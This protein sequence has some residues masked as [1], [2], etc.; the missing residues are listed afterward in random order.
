[1]PANEDINAMYVQM[2][3]DFYKIYTTTIKIDSLPSCNNVH[4]RRLQR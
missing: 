1:M 4:D 2:T 3:S